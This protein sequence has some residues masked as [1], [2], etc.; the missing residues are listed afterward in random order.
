MI[1]FTRNGVDDLGKYGIIVNF[2]SPNY[3]VMRPL[4]NFIGAKDKDEFED[5]TTN[6]SNLKGVVLTS[7]DIVEVVLYLPSDESKCI[8]D[9]NL[10]VDGGFT[11]VKHEGG[12]YMS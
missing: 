7:C 10:V 1:G 6:I 5:W 2:I 11:I 4:V 12:L 3:V 8:N 9:H